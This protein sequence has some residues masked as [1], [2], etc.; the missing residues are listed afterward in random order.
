MFNLLEIQDHNGY[1]FSKYVQLLS[2]KK[3]NSF[4]KKILK[5]YKPK[6]ILD[7]GCGIPII[8]KYALMAGAEKVYAIDS[9]PNLKPL[10]E[11]FKKQHPNR[12]E[13]FITD[14]EN[15]PDLKI[16]CVVSELFAPNLFH[17]NVIKIYSACSERYKG[18]DFLPS[19]WKLK[20]ALCNV[21]DIDKNIEPVLGF[22][23]EENWLPNKWRMLK[24]ER[25]MK[26]MYPIDTTQLNFEE[27]TWF[28]F[29]NSTLDSWEFDFYCDKT[30]TID[31]VYINF[32]LSSQGHVL[33]LNTVD[34]QDHWGNQF[35]RLEEREVT[36]R[37]KIK[38]F[39]QDDKQHI[40]AKWID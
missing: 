14:H 29:K 11:D 36:G 30:Q 15:L 5:E 18:I 16:D 8:S 28:E 9:N 34:F 4:Y 21:R 13:Y 2:D 3:R 20:T 1:N 26:F 32:M 33:N 12:F 23:D 19:L 38:V 27:T 35:I 39:L 6:R 10:L 25:H 37:A 7:Y 17:E 40:D 31:C 22:S 24:G